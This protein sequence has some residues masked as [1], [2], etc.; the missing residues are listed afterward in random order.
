[1]LAMGGAS[2]LEAGARQV[3]ARIVL[4]VD[5]DAAGRAVVARIQSARPLGEVRAAFSPA[6]QDAADTLTAALEQRAATLEFEGGMTRTEADR[7]AW[8]EYR[9]GTTHE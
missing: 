9:K 1:M 4:V 3:K 5:G 2:G 6:G 7:A 8:T